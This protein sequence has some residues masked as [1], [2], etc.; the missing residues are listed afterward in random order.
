MAVFWPIHPVIAAV[1]SGGSGNLD[2]PLVLRLEFIQARG[3]LVSTE[4]P[5]GL[6]IVA[7]S[8]SRSSQMLASADIARGAAKARME[9]VRCPAPTAAIDPKRSFAGTAPWPG[10]AEERTRC[11]GGVRVL[12]TE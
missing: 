5:V 3:G 4:Q 10:L 9:A 1:G 6:M 2:D 7:P 11:A 8:S 12:M